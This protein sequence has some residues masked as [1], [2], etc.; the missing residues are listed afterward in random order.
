MEKDL[1]WLNSLQGIAKMALAINDSQSKTIER[2]ETELHHLTAKKLPIK[3][4]KNK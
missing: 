4:S 3:K 2:L 1:K